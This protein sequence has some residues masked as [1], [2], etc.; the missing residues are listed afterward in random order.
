MR[1]YQLTNHYSTCILP[2]EELFEVVG[3]VFSE[4]GISGWDTQIDF[5][6]ETPLE[7]FLT[8]GMPLENL[9]EDQRA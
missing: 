2:Y 4:R 3:Q 7:L 6:P 5:N 1:F 8:Q 9:E